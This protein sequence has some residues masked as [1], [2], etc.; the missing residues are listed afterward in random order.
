VSTKS[1][2]SRCAI[3]KWIDD[4]EPAETAAVLHVFRE[5]RVAAGP[6]RGGDDQRIVE[7]Q[8]VIFGERS[9]GGMQLERQRQRRIDQREHIG[10]R[11]GARRPTLPRPSHPVPCVRDDRDTPL[12]DETAKV[13]DM[14]SGN[15]KYFGKWDSTGEKQTN[16]GPFGRVSV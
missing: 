9:R 10:D 15:E 14:L 11:F 2:R 16:T 5:Q 4:G 13:V 8:P 12:W 3:E 6:E 1:G 7:R